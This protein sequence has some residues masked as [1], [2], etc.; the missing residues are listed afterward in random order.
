VQRR[1]ELEIDNLRREFREREASLFSR[2]KDQ[3]DCICDELEAKFGRLTTLVECNVQ[4][5]NDKTLMQEETVTY[6]LSTI[7]SLTELLKTQE[8]DCQS[9]STPSCVSPSSY[10]GPD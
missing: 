8:E 9:S 6:I 1:I 10:D 5:Q 7:Q 4:W 2:L 3:L